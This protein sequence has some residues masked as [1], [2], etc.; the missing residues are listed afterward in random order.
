LKFLAVF[1]LLS[2]FRILCGG[3]NFE[4][5]HSEHFLDVTDRVND[6]RLARAV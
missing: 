5:T 2:Q 3:I 4:L 1:A 6:E